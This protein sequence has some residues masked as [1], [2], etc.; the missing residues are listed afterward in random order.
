MGP[1]PKLAALV[2]LGPGGGRSDHA[3]AL[4]KFQ[5]HSWS[6]C[7]LLLPLLQAE[8]FPP[9]E[10]A[11][12]NEFVVVFSNAGGRARGRTTV[13]AFASN[14]SAA[15]VGEYK[16]ALH[17]L[18]VR[19][20]PAVVAALIANHPD[21]VLSIELNTVVRACGKQSIS[22]DVPKLAYLGNAAREA[23]KGPWGL[24]HIDQVKYSTRGCRAIPSTFLCWVCMNCR[25]A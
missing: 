24:D 22:A 25:C 12:S 10:D 21:D 17:G 13:A 16:S 23:S 19:G 4:F 9:T 2:T 3:V 7:P 15:V 20:K 11:V 6:M 5:V 18:T 14:T 1:W 8:S